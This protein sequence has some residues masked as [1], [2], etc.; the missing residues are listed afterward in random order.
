MRKI[1]INMRNPRWIIIAA[2]TGVFFAAIVWGM[3]TFVTSKYPGANDFFQR[4]NGVQAY[5]MR[6]LDP[7]SP[8]V[9]LSAENYL[10]GHPYDPN[11]QLDEYPGDFLYPFH[12]VLL[13]APLGF[14][15]Y[16]LASAIWLALLSLLI[17]LNFWMLIQL[18]KWRMSLPMMA[19]GIIWTLS[20]YPAA[21][22]LFLGQVGVFVVCM[23]I[24]AI[25][26]LTQRHDVLAGVA[27]ALST[28][29]PQISI[30]IILFLMLWALRFGRGRVMLSFGVSLI[31]WLGVSFVMVPGWLGEWL[32]QAAQ[33][34]N[35]T[36]VS[37]PVEIVTQIYLPFLGVVGQWVITT[38]LLG[39]MI[40]G[41]WRVLWKRD[42]VWFAWALAVTITV[43]QSVLIRT[44]TP[45]YVIFFFIL[46]FYFRQ[47][48][49]LRSTLITVSAMIVLSIALWVLFLSTLNSRIESAANFLPLPILSIVLL[50]LTPHLWRKS[51]LVMQP[52]TTAETV[53]AHAAR[54]LV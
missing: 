32:A 9:T 48:A 35:Y 52:P 10:Y 27:L 25:W 34:T 41:W 6:G 4:W 47:L 8:T 19:F 22:G 30:L 1:N 20:F 31:V 12:L 7:Y 29:K 46:I 39:V 23:Q 42:E 40:L 45:H 51:N 28:V 5:L 53:A 13:L 11:P 50:L 54:S 49:G 43:T 24:V 26:A 14:M 36:R 16:A 44:A 15:S 21:R 3:Y 37:S 2:M 17:M 33:Y 38:L 18:F